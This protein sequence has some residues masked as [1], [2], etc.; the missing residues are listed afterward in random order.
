M[1]RSRIVA[2][3]VGLQVLFFAG[4]AW[5]EESRLEEGA[6]QSILVTVRPVDPRDLL[7]GQYMQL[8]YRFSQAQVFPVELAVADGS[9]IWVVLG[10][11]GQFYVPKDAYDRRPEVVASGEVV[12]RGRVAGG[13]FVFGIERY[14][15]PEGTEA[16]DWPDLTVRLRVGDDGRPR[17]EQV[18][19]RGIPWP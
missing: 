19:L 18:Y 4:W 5:L 3:W 2:V 13:R 8:G 7:R 17:I 15:V 9:V 1:T 10:P 6:G 16:P 14:F 12:L 11:E